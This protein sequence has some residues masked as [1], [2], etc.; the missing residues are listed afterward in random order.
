ML[1]KLGPDTEYLRDE[2]EEHLQRLQ[3]LLGKMRDDAALTQDRD[4][5][6]SSALPEQGL[7]AWLGDSD[8]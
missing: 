1:E 8:E 3:V 6:Q 4:Y 2:L 5:L 7:S